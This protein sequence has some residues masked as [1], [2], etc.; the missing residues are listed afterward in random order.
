ML[1]PLVAQLI[2]I[3]VVAF[4][5]TVAAFYVGALGGPGGGGIAIVIVTA[6]STIFLYA[7][8]G[9]PIFLGLTTDGWRS[10]RSNA[11]GRSGWRTSG[12]RVAASRS[13]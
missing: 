1:F 6:I 10:E 11:S 2:A 13:C 12:C 7:A 5:F 9:I 4:L 3:V 8:Y